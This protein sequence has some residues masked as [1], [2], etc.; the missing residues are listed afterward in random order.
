VAGG[1]RGWVTQCGTPP[2]LLQRSA[3]QKVRDLK[4]KSVLLLLNLNSLFNGFECHGKETILI[5][6]FLSYHLL[7]A[8]MR[9]KFPVHVKL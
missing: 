8:G 7:R 6:F 4:K 1:P 5:Y 2:S 3:V 9:V